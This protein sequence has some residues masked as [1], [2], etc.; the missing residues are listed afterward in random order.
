MHQEYRL[1]FLKLRE[2]SPTL[3][4]SLKMEIQNFMINK[5]FQI[6]DKMFKRILTLSSRAVIALINGLFKTDYPLDSTLTYNATE[7][8]NDNLQKTLADTIIT[9]NNQYSY[10]LEAQ[11]YEDESIV[12]RVYSYGYH[13]AVKH[14]QN[15]DIL[16]FPEPVIIYLCPLDHAVTEHSLIID[17]G[18]QGEFVYQVPVCNFPE[19]TPIEIIEKNMIILL[20]FYI[21][22]LRKAIEK[23]RTPENLNQLKYLIFDVI[24]KSI[25]NSVSAGLLSKNDARVLRSLLLKLY[26]HVYSDF[27]EME[28]DG[29]NDMIE[30]ALILD[31]DVIEHEHRKQMKAQKDEYT[32]KL[33]EKDLIIKAY[34]LL[35]QGVSVEEISAATGLTPEEISNLT[36]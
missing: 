4:Q 18:S 9:V 14:R 22:K 1:T 35:A 30:E 16:K 31:I 33:I 11:M 7:N 34:K 17:Y 15:C 20:P 36:K 12:C 6:Y 13:H 21:L 8:V 19:L 29:M 10:H 2:A 3:Y 24:L 26:R 27:K 25:E 5:T 32:Q 23:A 28:E